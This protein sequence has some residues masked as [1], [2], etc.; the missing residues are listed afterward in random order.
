M[1]VF[2]NSQGVSDIGYFGSNALDLLLGTNTTLSRHLFLRYTID[3]S[4]SAVF[5]DSD[6]QTTITDFDTY[7]T[8]NPGNRLRGGRT[9]TNGA[10]RGLDA[11]P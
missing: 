2:T 11:Q 1:P 5:P 7:Y 10:D 3:D 8:A 6:H 9:F 4:Y